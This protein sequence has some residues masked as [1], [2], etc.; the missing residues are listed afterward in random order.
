V[1]RLWQ[2]S[3]KSTRGWK[4]T[5]WGQSE[6]NSVWILKLPTL[7]EIFCNISFTPAVTSCYQLHALNVDHTYLRLCYVMYFRCNWC[8]NLAAVNCILHGRVLT[9]SAL[10]MGITLEIEVA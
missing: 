6:E 3:H 10:Q 9:L 2:D 5:F 1:L 4:V 7:L 8:R